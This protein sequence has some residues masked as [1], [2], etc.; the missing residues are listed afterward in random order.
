MLFII[1]RD[2]IHIHTGHLADQGHGLNFLIGANFIG[3]SSLGADACVAGGVDNHLGSDLDDVHLGHD[4]ETCHGVAVLQYVNDL[5]VQPGG[6]V[7]LLG[8]QIVQHDL[9]DLGVVEVADVLVGIL[10][11]DGAHVLQDVSQLPGH[12][13]HAAVPFIAEADPRALHTGRKLTAQAAVFLNDQ[14][15]CAVPGS[16]QTG[17]AA[18][19]AAAGDN[20][21]KFHLLHW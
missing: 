4:H 7:R 2:L 1:F 19:R 20:D 16:C 6:Q 5:G 17:N 11:H 13:A 15:L 21:I 12:A 14:G 3:G 10:V 9:G 8:G 18:G